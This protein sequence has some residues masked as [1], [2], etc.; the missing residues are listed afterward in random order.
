MLDNPITIQTLGPIA[1]LDSTSIDLFSHYLY[2]KPCSHSYLYSILNKTDKHWNTIYKY[3]NNAVLKIFVFM[4]LF[5]ISI[6]IITLF[7]NEMIKC[8]NY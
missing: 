3:T 7:S 5:I 8:M 2:N 1:T 6:L 4:Y